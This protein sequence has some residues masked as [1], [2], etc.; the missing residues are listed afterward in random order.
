MMLHFAWAT[1]IMCNLVD[2]SV[3]ITARLVD[4]RAPLHLAAWYDSTAEILPEKDKKN[5]K[6][7]EK[8]EKTDGD[9]D[10]KMEDPD[11]FEHPSSK[12]NW[13]FEDDENIHMFDTNDRTR[14]MR[15]MKVRMMKLGINRRN[16]RGNL[17]KRGKFQE[18]CQLDIIEFD[19]YDWD[20]RAFLCHSLWLESSNP[21]LDALIA[22]DAK[23]E[24]LQKTHTC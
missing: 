12:D 16:L 4:G 8:N 2:A 19:I 17:P 10:D 18:E 15:K 11:T 1:D 20:L 5:A 24:P 7:A 13:S 21:A 14:K 22:G 3:M 9:G 23:I 6:E